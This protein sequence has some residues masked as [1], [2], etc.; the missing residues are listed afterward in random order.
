RREVKRL[1]LP[2]PRFPYAAPTWP[3]TVP[4]PP[5]ERSTG[6]NYETA[7]ARRYGPRLLRRMI[8]A[9]ITRPVIRVVASP[10][11]DGLDR[12]EAVEAPVVFAANHASHVDTGLVLSCLPE[13]FRHRTVVAAAA[14]YFFD[15]RWKGALSALTINAVPIERV[16]VSPQSTRLAVDLLAE[17]W[18]V[19]I[20]PEG[21]RSPDGWAQP[22]RAGA[23]HLAVRSGRP[24][25]PVH[26]EGT[27]RI[28]KRGAKRIRRSTAHVTFGRPL[29]PDP[30]EGTREF[31]A[32]V[33]KEIAVLA[34]EQ[35]HGLW[36]ARRRAAS[37]TTP[38][39]TGP[40]VAQWRRAWALG[41]GRT[42]STTERAWPPQ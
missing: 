32:R 36:V 29:E 2:R 31:T 20:Y 40:S 21:G 24:L 28:L 6:I 5:V 42:R 12:I 18:S 27:R 7:W 10:D 4:R 1:P 19:L 13:R 16:R 38:A 35:A 26:I 33:E 8:T 34:D 39:L 17:G 9:G 14:D 3:G 11:V 23:A 37:G 25:V 30:A 22:H 41:E 15:K